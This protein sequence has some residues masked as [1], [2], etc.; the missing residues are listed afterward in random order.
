VGYNGAMLYL[1]LAIIASFSIALLVKHNETHGARTEVVLASNYLSAS[2]IGWGVLLLSPSGA[3]IRGISR[4]TWLL[5]AGGALLWPGAFF[6]MM[7]AVRRYGVSLAG[8]VARLSLSVPVVFALLFLRER[9]TPATVLGV[10]GAFAAFLLLSPLRRLAGAEQ[11]PE[12]QASSS[13]AAWVFPA[14]VLVFG[15]VDLWVN[16]HHTVAPGEERF[17][18]VVLIFTGA[19]IGAWLVVGLRRLRPE[20]DSVGRGLLLGVPNFFSTYLLMEA[21]RSP[22]FADLSTVVYTLYSAAGVVLAFGAGAVIWKEPLT[23]KNRLGVVLAV[24]AI[25]LLN[26]R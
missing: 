4:E 5:G 8:S 16:L 3:V 21:L 11:A 20:G 17:L 19:G 1:A 25:V 22:A 18:F 15:V 10:A 14:L 7:W 26:V 23:L 12:R 2:A 13:Q 6:L 9:L 24:V